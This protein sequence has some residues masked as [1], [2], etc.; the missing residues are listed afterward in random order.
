MRQSFIEIPPTSSSLSSS[1]SET[2]P[3]VP[4]TP[5]SGQLYGGFPPS[6]YKSD[7]NGGYTFR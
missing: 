2:L 1:A 7:E 6:L 5:L 4:C 3:S